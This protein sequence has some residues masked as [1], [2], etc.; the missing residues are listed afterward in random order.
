MNQW[1]GYAFETAIVLE[2]AHRFLFVNTAFAARRRE[3]PRFISL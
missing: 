3:I 1:F 2:S